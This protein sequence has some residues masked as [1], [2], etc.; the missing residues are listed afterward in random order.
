MAKL[1]IYERDIND[2]RAA[3]WEA[4]DLSQESFKSGSRSWRKTGGKYP[5]VAFKN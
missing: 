1:T 2:D 3:G 4:A 5:Q